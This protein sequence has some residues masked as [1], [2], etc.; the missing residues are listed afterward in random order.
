MK[1]CNNHEILITKNHKILILAKNETSTQLECKYAVQSQMNN[2]QNFPFYLD[3]QNN[4]YEVDLL[5]TSPFKPIPY[6]HWIKNNIQQKTTQINRRRK[7]N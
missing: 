4:H 6:S 7:F 2:L 1:N 5:G 3:C